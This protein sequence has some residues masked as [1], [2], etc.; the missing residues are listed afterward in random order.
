MKIN[1]TVDRTISILELISN[2]PDGLTLN[3][4][5]EALQIPTSSTFDILQTLLINDM[6][7]KIQPYSKRYIL[8]TKTF[9]IGS[10]YNVPT[11]DTV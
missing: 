1:R 5:S 9:M 10:R 8:G 3:E 7:H 6:I 2:N 11:S 4:I